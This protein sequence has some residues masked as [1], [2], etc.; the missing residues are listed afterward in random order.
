MGNFGV[1]GKTLRRQRNKDKE[2]SSQKTKIGT[3]MK[4]GICGV[5]RTLKDWISYT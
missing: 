4:A 2:K 1:E 5:Q 3:G